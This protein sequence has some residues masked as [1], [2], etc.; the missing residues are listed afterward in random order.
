MEIPGTIDVTN[1]QP[2]YGF[3]SVCCYFI[4]ISSL[5]RSRFFAYLPLFLFFFSNI[6]FTL[7][8][9]RIISFSVLRIGAICVRTSFHRTTKK[10]IDVNRQQSRHRTRYTFSRFLS[11]SSKTPVACARSSLFC[12]FFLYFSFTYF[13]FI[14]F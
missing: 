11:F 4:F 14:S 2:I 6:S 12:F 13:S 3:N 8:G 5:V 10:T 1:L 9:R 7:S